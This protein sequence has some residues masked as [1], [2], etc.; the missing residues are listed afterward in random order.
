MLGLAAW[1]WTTLGASYAI[2]L[3]F[4]LRILRQPRQPMATLLWVV[5]IFAFPW[6]VLPLYLLVGERRIIR[7]GRKKRRRAGPILRAMARTRIE[8]PT[9]YARDLPA[10][11]GARAAIEDG[12]LQQLIDV[13]D[14]LGDFRPTMGNK[15][16]V[17]TSASETYEAILAAIRDAREHIHLEYYIFRSDETGKLFV[18]ELAR[19]ARS[20]VEVRLL[21]DG[22]G[23]WSTRE[24][25]F[26][27]LLE[28]GGKLATFSPGIPLRR[29]WHVNC[30]NHRKIVVVDGRVAFTGSQN[31]G[32]EY[33]GLLRRLGPWKDTHLRL[34]G[35]CV[36]E[37]QEVFVEDWYFACAEDLA[38]PRYL[39]R[40]DHSGPS[41]CTI[42]PT[43]PDQN[44][45]VLSHVF[46]AAL[47][48]ARKSIRISTPYFVPDPGLIMA[49]QHAGHRGVEVEI[50]IP[51]RTDEKLVLWAGR[52]YYEELIRAGVK[53]HEYD[54]GMLHSKS[55][56]IDDTWSL[57]GSAN[58]DVRSF[59]YNFE[60]TVAV[61][62]DH[63]A[64]TLRRDFI[65]DVRKS[66]QIPHQRPE[67]QRFG[68]S[69]LEG[70][71]R[72]FSPLL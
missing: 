26:A 34:E 21:L 13:S 68:P 17:Y 51:A 59:I 10:F 35:P 33:R 57:V 65:N 18:D 22:V 40:P 7:R 23:S 67:L 31:I 4:I 3:W 11:Q 63:I 5:G 1:E 29:P 55:V 2:G 38:S 69:V 15:V 49:L 66:R 30:R 14:N 24:R 58:M 60:V 61:F 25:F 28:A 46:F 20:G 56:V 12:S 71:A 41:V 42:Y 53:V 70:F 43:G 45:A 8:H 27:P 39:H 50:L 48:L 16:D 9:A 37:L 54:E 6:V 72:L 36:L 62:D 44:E 52:S 47:A 19:K 64:K 32:D